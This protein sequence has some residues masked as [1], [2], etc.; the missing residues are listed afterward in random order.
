MLPAD[1]PAA[2]G[3]EGGAAVGVAVEDL[4]GSADAD[5]ARRA[6]T[7]QAALALV[8]HLGRSSDLL[9]GKSIQGWTKITFPGSVNMR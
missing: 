1:A 7:H 2:V 5:G 9:K 3:V 4:G 6:V 8:H